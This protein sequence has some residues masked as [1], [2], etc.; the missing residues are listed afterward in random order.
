MVLSFEM[1]VFGI[2]I[3]KPLSEIYA[4]EIV[5]Q[6]KDF[7]LGLTENEFY[8]QSWKE[9]LEKVPKKRFELPSS[10]GIFL[11]ND[12]VYF[13]WIMVISVSKKLL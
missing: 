2:Q 13:F 4:Q 6:C 8:Y 11:K 10:Y 9:K 5:L 1:A 12:C 3:W 7:L